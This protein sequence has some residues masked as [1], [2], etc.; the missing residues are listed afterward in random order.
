MK[1]ILLLV[2]L[3]VIAGIAGIVRSRTHSG[4]FDRLVSRN[5]TQNARDNFSQ[6]YQLAPGAVVELSDI[7]GSVKIE[8]SDTQTAEV[9]VE[10]TASNE[11][12]LSRRK[13][14]ID[15]DTNS[16]RVRGEKGDVG[17]FARLFGSKP[18]EKITLKLPRK[19]SLQTRGVNGAVTVGEIEGSVDLHGINGRVQ[20]AGATGSAEFKGINGSIVVGLKEINDQGVTLSGINGNIELQLAQGINADL[21]THGMNGRV[22]SD[23]GEVAI[24][25]SKRG[26]YSAR[27]GTGGSAITANG[28]NG[29]IRLTRTG[30]SAEVTAADLGSQDQS[31]QQKV[32][33]KIQDKVQEKIEKSK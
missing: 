15:A 21:E 28:I 31:V 5:A 22:V 26:T 12:A 7:N 1:R 17:F 2:A 33:Q 32:Q 10:R 13:I 18:S 14:T 9:L 27:I 29:N 16:L 3:V 23:I 8:T 11:E 24:D 20:I 4:D 19:I 6:S 25:K 30:A